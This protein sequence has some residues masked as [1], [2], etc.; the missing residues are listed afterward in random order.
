MN[1]RD[2][3]CRWLDWVYTVP[4]FD[5]FT[6]IVGFHIVLSGAVFAFAPP[7]FAPRGTLYLAM[8]Q[9]ADPL[10]WGL[11]VIVAGLLMLYGVLR[12]K[13]QYVASGAFQGVVAWAFAVALD[14][15]VFPQSLG[16]LANLSVPLVVTCLY[17]RFKSAYDLA[18][19]DRDVEV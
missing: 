15:I 3:T 6:F 14:I 17:I 5:V 4:P 19:G 7:E 11:W 16:G 13:K 18:L 8:Q 1:I 2:R 9:Y 10:I 12:G